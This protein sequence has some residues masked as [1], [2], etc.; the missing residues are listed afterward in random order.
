MAWK[1]WQQAGMAAE[2]EKHSHFKV[3]AARRES[4]LEMA[5]L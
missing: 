3:R 5:R 2:T 1:Q 4:K